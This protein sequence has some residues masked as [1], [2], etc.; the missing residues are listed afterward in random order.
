MS[1]YFTLRTFQIAFVFFSVVIAVW[2]ALQFQLDPKVFRYVSTALGVVDFSILT[3]MVCRWSDWKQSE[4]IV[5]L[6]WLLLTWGACFKVGVSFFKLYVYLGFGFAILL[7]IAL[8]GLQLMRCA[9]AE[10]GLVVWAD[11]MMCRPGNPA[12]EGYLWSQDYNCLLDILDENQ[13]AIVSVG[14]DG[15]V[16][17]MFYLRKLRNGDQD[18]YRAWNRHGCLT[19]WNGEQHIGRLFSDRCTELQ[20]RF[21]L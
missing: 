6:C 2:C 5:W 9:T 13:I 11:P 19:V 15:G 10:K 20:L 8:A 18:E 1:R 21:L 4:D 7:S 16:D 12:L 3:Y 14:N 17:E